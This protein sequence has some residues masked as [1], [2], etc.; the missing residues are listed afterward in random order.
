MA[1]LRLTCFLFILLFT[2]SSFSN[3]TA[4][5]HH[6][7]VE[8]DAVSKGK[9]VV[10]GEITSTGANDQR[11]GGRRMGSVVQVRKAKKVK[12]SGVSGETSQFAAG[13][14][15][16]QRK[17]MSNVACKQRV[18]HQFSKEADQKEFVAF[19]ADYRAPRHHPPKNN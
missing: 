10:D 4:H 18:G 9:G 3:I 2:T 19:N 8:V 7:A 6:Q 16:D 13:E 17:K 1:P 14:V 5:A 12:E 11:L 15:E